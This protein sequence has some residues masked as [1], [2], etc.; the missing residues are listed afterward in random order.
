VTMDPTGSMSCLNPRWFPVEVRPEDLV[1]PA[2]EAV[3]L[4][5][6]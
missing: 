2:P 3:K 5:D 4:G 6:G 1:P